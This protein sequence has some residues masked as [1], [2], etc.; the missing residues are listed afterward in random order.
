[1]KNKLI[2]TAIIFKLITYQFCFSFDF[3][4]KQIYQI[5]E[6]Y[7]ES[8]KYRT[9]IADETMK[10]ISALTPTGRRLL[11]KQLDNLLDENL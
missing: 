2:F 4:L 10:K 5:P 7:D 8:K 9:Y 1:M 3:N 6:N 11:E